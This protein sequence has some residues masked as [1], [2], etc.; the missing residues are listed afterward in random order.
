MSQISHIVAREILDSRGKPTV[1]AS[2][3]LEA[4]ISATA[5]VP[6]GASTGAAEAFELRDGDHERYD[7][8]G[9]RRAVDNINLV[10]RPALQGKC[11]LDQQDTDGTIR[12]LDSSGNKQNLGANAVLAVSLAA[13]R[14]AALYKRIPLYRHI[15]DSLL[16]R[17]VNGINC[18][19][20]PR[21]PLPMTNMISGGKHA[22]GNLDFQDVLIIPKGASNYPVGLEWIVRVYR[23]LGELLRKDGFE[24]YLVGDEGGYG[25]RLASNRQAVEYVVRAIEKAGL[26]PGEDVS[27]ALDVASTHFYRNGSYVLKAE[28]GRLLSSAEM[29]DR[30]AEWVQEFPI[31]CIEDG[32]A[33]ED[34]SGWQ[35]L[36]K[37][38]G[39]KVKLVGD[40]L[41]A[42]NARRLQK[43]IEQKAANAVLIKV[44]QIGTLSE[45][46]DTVLTAKRHGYATIISAR[47]GETEDDFLADLSVGVG[48]DYIKIGSIAR[49][50]R[51]AK[52]NRLLRIWEELTT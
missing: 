45:T 21:I 2:V 1:E 15:H 26:C 46:F 25:P 11:V 35:L 24:G 16:E 7:G 32:L 12:F 27:L 52:Y 34:W 23:R 47:S 13:S 4:G 3:H 14:A 41:F 43:G 40:D 30:L 33:E 48:G 17:A 28:Q 8:Q 6:S 38:L 9:V 42:T 19:F 31:D 50:E 37:R 5:S 51:L 36:T 44:N 49:S 18:N 39:G 10:I 20:A 22:G 29:V